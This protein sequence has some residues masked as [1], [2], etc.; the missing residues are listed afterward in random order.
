MLEQFACVR[1][2][3]HRK[4]GERVRLLL[5]NK[6]MV[7]DGEDLV[8]SRAMA[9]VTMSEDAV[10]RAGGDPLDELPPRATP[11][12]SS[13]T[14]L[15]RRTPTGLDRRLGSSAPTTRWRRSPAM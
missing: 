8:T 1:M 12:R 10:E 14:I 6:G 2:C 3:V 13:A 7:E 4:H 9:P 5:V 11:T 15:L